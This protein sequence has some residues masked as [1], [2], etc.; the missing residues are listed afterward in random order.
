MEL[1]ALQKVVGDIEA[2]GA[3]L[4]ALSPQRLQ[5]VA[6]MTRK[7]LLNFDVLWDQGNAYGRRLG[8]VF[9]VPEEHRKVYR[10]FGIDVAEHNGDDS[11]TLPMPARLVVD[12]D[13]VVR[14]VDGFA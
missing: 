13:G 1:Y 2:L 10:A 5:C 6:E 12:T 11:W 9:A 4:V 7:R 14:A 3:T 8:L